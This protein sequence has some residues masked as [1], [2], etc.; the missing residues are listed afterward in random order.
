MSTPTKDE[1]IAEWTGA[2][3]MLRPFEKH[4]PVLQGNLLAAKQ[5]LADATERG[6]TAE[7]EDWRLTV[8]LHKCAVAFNQANIQVCRRA[9]VRAQEKLGA[10]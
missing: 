1:L 8:H 5:Q 4:L 10:L 3:Q 6:D 7:I 2:E 9:A